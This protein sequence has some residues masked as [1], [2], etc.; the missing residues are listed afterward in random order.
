MSTCIIGICLGVVAW[1]VLLSNEILMKRVMTHNSERVRRVTSRVL[2]A[3]ASALL[4]RTHPSELTT[5][6]FGWPP[7]DHDVPNSLSLLKPLVLFSLPFHT[8]A[9]TSS[10][11]VFLRGET[12]FGDGM[13]QCSFIAVYVRRWTDYT[14]LEASFMP[15]HVPCLALGHLFLRFHTHLDLHHLPFSHCILLPTTPPPLDQPSIGTL[16]VPVF[17]FGSLGL[18]HASSIRV[19]ASDW[20]IWTSWRMVHEEETRRLVGLRRVT[21]EEVFWLSLVLLE[22]FEFWL[23][24]SKYVRFLAYL[25]D[26]YLTFVWMRSTRA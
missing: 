26:F 3:R 18:F 8:M 6:A 5:S 4:V 13:Q 7:Q 16:H 9:W 15:T 2:P 24:V 21:V 14:I 19:F 12:Y 25:T 17:M 11:Q 10:P 22:C 23:D 1:K 20:M